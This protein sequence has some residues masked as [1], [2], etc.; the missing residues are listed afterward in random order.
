MAAWRRLDGSRN[1]LTNQSASRR[2]LTERPRGHVVPTHLLTSRGHVVEADEEA[3]LL[4]LRTH[5][6]AHRATK[7]TRGRAPR[8]SILALDLLTHAPI[9]QGATW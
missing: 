7:A 4:T 1:L 2:L 6:H 5:S 3:Y 8:G 9:G